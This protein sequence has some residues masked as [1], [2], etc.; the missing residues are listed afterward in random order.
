MS[1][2]SRDDD[3]TSFHGLLSFFPV[4]KE[5]SKKLMNDETE[6]QFPLIILGSP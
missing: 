1:S 2:V 4:T 5:T 6:K 3:V